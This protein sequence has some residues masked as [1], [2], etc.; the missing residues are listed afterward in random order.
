VGPEEGHEDDQRAGERD[1]DRLRELGLFSLEKRRLEGDVIATC[2][3]LKSTYRKAE[4]GLFIRACSDWMIGNTFK[5]EENRFRLDI[6]M[7]F[8]TVRVV[9]QWDR[10]PREVVNVP[11]MEVFKP[12]LDGAL[13]NLV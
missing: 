3:Y 9:R 7:K 11:T 8:F 4:E 5:L 13:S 10:L 1:R 12:R 2:Q 6:R